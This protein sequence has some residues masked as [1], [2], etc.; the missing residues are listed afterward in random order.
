VSEVDA[1]ISLPHLPIKR[2]AGNNAPAHGIVQM[3]LQPALEGQAREP[4]SQEI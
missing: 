3:A 2:S 4:K 1:F